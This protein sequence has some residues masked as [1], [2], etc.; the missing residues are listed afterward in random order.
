MILQKFTFVFKHRSGIQ[1]KVADAL[2]RRSSLLAVLSI[3]LIGFNLLKE[4]YPNDEDFAAIWSHCSRNE[5]VEVFHI[6]QGFLFKGN[7]FCI[8]RTSLRE[9]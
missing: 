9:H 3:E 7:L 2:S 1:N 8:P 6:Q 4:L 5:H